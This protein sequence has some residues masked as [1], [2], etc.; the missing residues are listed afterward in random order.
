VGVRPPLALFRRPCRILN[1]F[2]S[3]GYF[4]FL[5][6]GDDVMKEELDHSTVEFVGS[7]D[8]TAKVSLSVI[9]NL[10]S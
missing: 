1:H 8:K 3:E 6:Q 9:F 4:K 7:G 2:D 5:F 10:F